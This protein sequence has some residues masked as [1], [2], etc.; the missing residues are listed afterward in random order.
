M[1]DSVQTLEDIN[2]AKSEEVDHHFLYFV[3]GV[4]PKYLTSIFSIFPHLKILEYPKVLIYMLSNL[5]FI[6]QLI[7]SLNYCSY[8]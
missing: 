3:M 2:K 4:Y 1:E 8:N 7:Y 6:F 5:Y